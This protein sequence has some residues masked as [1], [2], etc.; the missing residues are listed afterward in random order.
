MVDTQTLVGYP[1]AMSHPQATLSLTAHECL[2]GWLHKGMSLL[3]YGFEA[4]F[5]GLVDEL[6]GDG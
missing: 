2:R 4:L 6:V 5:G 3:A 1:Q